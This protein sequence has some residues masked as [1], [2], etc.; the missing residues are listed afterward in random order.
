MLNELKD[1]ES[2]M[3]VIMDDLIPFADQQKAIQLLTKDEEIR[4][5]LHPEIHIQLLK[6]LLA[7]SMALTDQ[8]QISIIEE[9]IRQSLKECS[10][11]D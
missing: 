9:K 2:I 10:N 8:K 5:R 11:L 3:K 7:G 4:K 1:P 6:Y